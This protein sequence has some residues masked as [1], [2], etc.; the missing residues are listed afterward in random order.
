MA[1]INKFKIKYTELINEDVESEGEMIIETKDITWSLEQFGRNRN[2]VKM[3]IKQ[4]K[5]K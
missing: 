5:T 2:I 1:D 3:D 4:V